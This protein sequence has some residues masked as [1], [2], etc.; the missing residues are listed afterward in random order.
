MNFGLGRTLLLLASV[1]T[2]AAVFAQPV[3][4]APDRRQQISKVTEHL[5]EHRVPSRTSLRVRRESSNQGATL[6]A[7]V[8]P[9]R[10]YGVVQFYD[11]WVKIGAPV[12][13]TSGVAHFSTAQ[14]PSGPHTFVATYIG[15]WNFGASSSDPHTLKTAHPRPFLS[16]A[17]PGSV[18][19]GSAATFVVTSG[20]DDLSGS[21]DLVE[22]QTVIGSGIL[23]NGSAT[24]TTTFAELGS[25]TVIA[26]AKATAGCRARESAAITVTV[27]PAQ[28]DG[29]GGASDSPQQT[30]ETTIGGGTLTL[31]IADGSTVV[32]PTPVL[33]P[34]ADA[35]S[36]SGDIHAITVTDSRAHAT[37]F[38]VSG[39]VGDFVRDSGGGDINGYNLG[40]TPLVIDS[41]PRM[42]VTP[43]P[44]VDPAPAIGSGAVPH[45]QLAGLKAARALAVAAGGT[46]T[47]H[48]GAHLHL[49]VPSNTPAGSYEATLTLTA[50]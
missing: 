14:L 11:N 48:L 40:W 26:R 20:P 9:S 38:T 43:G 47:V 35:L 37:G 46:G 13:L 28:P 21:V 32:L 2:V 22:G 19:K 23:S 4:A 34:T 39:M 44:Q 16:L 12:P 24:V 50:I 15:N 8:L 29:G 25:H 36:T 6:E 10:A 30:I 49:F 45:N 5:G 27:T 3:S 31:S 18:P 41:S 33:N 7:R 17:G 42:N 1:A